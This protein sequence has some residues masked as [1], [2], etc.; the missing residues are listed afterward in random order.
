ML[1]H[2]SPASPFFSILLLRLQLPQVGRRV[3]ERR[4]RPRRRRHRDGRAHLRLRGPA[5]FRLGRVARARRASSPR[6]V[7]FQTRN[8][9]L[10]TRREASTRL[11][12]ERARLVRAL[13]KRLRP[14]LAPLIRRARAVPPPPLAAPR[15][16]DA[17]VAK[18]TNLRSLRSVDDGSVDDVGVEYAAEDAP[19]VRRRELPVVAQSSAARARRSEKRR[20][21]FR[22]RALLFLPAEPEPRFRGRSRFSFPPRTGARSAKTRAR[23]RPAPKSG[24]A[25]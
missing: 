5:P 17:T 22:R 20:F 1:I 19:A 16:E 11:R 24:T 2:A 6:V 14:R 15:V 25:P 3:E 9:I 13:Q 18:K 10:A 4:R 7:G 21:F 23:T 12:L 8:A